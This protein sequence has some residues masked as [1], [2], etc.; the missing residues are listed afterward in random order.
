MELAQLNTLFNTNLESQH[1]MMT[2]GGW[3]VEQLGDIPK[4]G[5]EFNFSPL[6]FQVL[7]ADAKHISRLYIRKRER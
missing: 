3:L 2:V 7:E 1:Q 4:S 6:F 5:R